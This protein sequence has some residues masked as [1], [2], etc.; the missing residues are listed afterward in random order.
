[1][2]LT[3]AYAHIWLADLLEVLHP[4]RQG[5]TRGPEVGKTSS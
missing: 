5:L 3:S 4:A 2:P 1:M